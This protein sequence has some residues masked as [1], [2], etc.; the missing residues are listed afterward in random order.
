MADRVYLPKLTDEEYE[1]II[2][3]FVYLKGEAT[4]DEIMGFLARCDKAIWIANMIRMA[5]N[6]KVHA[7]WSEEDQNF[8]FQAKT[9]QETD[10]KE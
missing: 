5:A 4:K 10:E 9:T 6:V 3:S 7:G 1:R 8:V 2:L